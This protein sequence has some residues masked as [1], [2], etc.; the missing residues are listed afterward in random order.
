MSNTCAMFITER[1]AVCESYYARTHLGTPDNIY[2]RK[3]GTEVF[4]L[5]YY[6]ALQSYKAPERCLSAGI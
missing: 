6:H 2:G 5:D 4:M 3:F 1:R